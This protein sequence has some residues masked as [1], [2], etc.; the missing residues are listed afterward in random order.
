ME[1]VSA[2]ALKKILGNQL[3]RN[4]F[5]GKIQELQ[6]GEALK[7]PASEWK[8]KT[9]LAQYFTATFNKKGKVIATRKVGDDYYIIKL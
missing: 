4:E 6:K 1:K 3:S 2:E 7:I 5:A 8:R 9:K